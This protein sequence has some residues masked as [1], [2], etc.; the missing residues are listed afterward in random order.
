MFILCI[1]T[2]HARGLGHLY[3]S[4]TLAEEL[5]RRGVK[6]LFLINEHE[7]SLKIVRGRDFDFRTYDLAAKPGSWERGLLEEISG[8][9][10]WIN[11]RLD[12]TTE[13]AEAVKEAGLALVTFDDR[14]EGAALAGLNVSALVFEDVDLLKGARV[15]TGPAYAVLNPEI[16]TY[17]RRRDRLGSILVTLGGAD[18]YGVTVSVARWLSTAKHAA[19][20]ITGPAFQ[21]ED[22]LA[23]VIAGVPG[24]L[25]THKSG[26]ASLAREMSYHDL[27][28]TGGGLTPF[29]AAAGGL[30]SIVIAN[31]M[32]EVPVGMALQRMGASIFAGYHR[33]VDFD[34]IDL[35]LPIAQMSEGALSALDLKGVARVA[36]LLGEISQ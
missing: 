8:A 3:R 31:E 30:P 28:I 34:G 35:S 21:H 6:I 12:T 13:H 10:L 5:R 36:D 2:S 18:T 15:L 29:E 25:L 32:F 20:I 23:A 1:E 19:T 33:N 7:P 24:G 22:E 4:L 14:G 26:V 11:D 27:A 9:A 16:E 17:R